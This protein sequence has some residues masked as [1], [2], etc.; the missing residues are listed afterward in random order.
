M[1]GRTISHY[2]IL[3]KLGGGGMGVVYKAEDLRLG[4]LVALKFVT[5]KL[6]Q[7]PEALERFKRE[8]RA[9]SALNHFNICTIH[10][11]DEHEG[12]PF[13]AMELLEGATLTHRIGGK[14]LKLEPLLELAVQIADG[15][16]A[17]HQK[18]II[19]RDIKPANIFVTS[20]GKAK[21]LDFG[22]AKLAPVSRRA[23]EAAAGS[24]IATAS[25]REEHLTNPGAVMG[26]VTYMSPEQVRG[27]ELD[28]RTDLFSFGAVLYE[29]ATSR[30]PFSGNTSAAIFGAILHQS[31]KI[32]LSLNPDLPPELNRIIT[33]A[34]EK[35]RDLRYQS[36]S[37]L[38]ADLRRL[39]RDTESARAAIATATAPAVARPRRVVRSVA[40]ALGA[41]A[42]LAVILVV[43]RLFVANV[44][45]RQA[46]QAAAFSSIRIAPV[47]DSGK[48]FD[49]AISP[50]GRYVVYAIE[51]A[52]QQSVWVRQVA[53]GSNVRIL[54]SEEVRYWG[55][56]FSRD[57][58]YVY[59][60]QR[61]RGSPMNLLYQT[62]ALGGVPRQLVTDV[63]SPVAISPDEK[64]LA[65]VRHDSRST[66]EQD[67]LLVVNA[68][69]GDERL[70]ATRKAP[71]FFGVGVAWSPDG[72]TLAVA[73]GNNRPIGL[74]K[75]LVV[76][77]AGGPEQTISSQDWLYT[78]RLAWLPDQGGLVM[79]AI[80]KQ[81]RRA[82]WY[83]AHPGGTARRITQ[84]L[85]FYYGVGLTA[86]AR[87]LV[88]VQ[89]EWL[90]RLWIA[91]KGE[92]KRARQF[93]SGP[94]KCEG[95]G[96]AWTPDGNLVYSSRTGT[97]FGLWLRNLDGGNPRQLTTSSS[98]D[99]RPV[100]SPDGH[101]IV[102][103]SGR[104]GE[105]NLWRMDA[106]GS[107]LKQLTRGNYDVSPQISPEGKWLVYTSLSQRAGHYTLW[108]MPIEG[109][110]PV[111]LTQRSVSGGRPG[112]SP[113][114]RRIAFQTSDPQTQKERIA[115]MPFDGGEPTQWIELPPDAV[116]IAGD[117]TDLWWMPD[118]Q[119]I[120]CVR[121]SKG[122]SNLWSLSISGSPPKQLTN[123]DADEIA[124]YAWSRD[125]LQLAVSRGIISRDVVL[126][127][128]FR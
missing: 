123:F 65:F 73:A 34:L 74:Y 106:D 24:A 49:A 115:I 124:G 35:D 42:V 128:N 60:L 76:P 58:N 29:M 41:L 117:P 122:I 101:A 21:I 100:V 92:A 54:P 126:I 68:D 66:P 70:V 104:S 71:L 96:V 22:L 94:S 28:A 91:P 13:I 39:E 23:G 26:T 127:T 95:L 93:T 32:P 88:T 47:T 83:L 10:E 78:G 69:G 97:V 44:S 55:L 6:A 51:E 102:F 119:S 38:R 48:A 121:T 114:G 82:L 33:K 118:G 8:A 36:A 14:P 112:I 84:D 9:A 61:P 27:E 103:E 116:Q 43:Y 99:W 81:G 57:G 18:G 50:D 4:R 11:I 90:F 125:G 37:D 111:E 53:T 52:E 80:E 31:P 110:E 20:C 25:M 75:V 109:G 5:E 56:A 19:H 7:R 87:T 105:L 40:A 3:E 12:Q 1:T 79:D 120:S 30:L 113:D 46:E 85:N 107:N 16:D 77:T 62:P 64:Q 45:T 15:L 67:R 2:R 17:A 72:K 108:R 89:G 86:D 59:Y 63:N 98:I